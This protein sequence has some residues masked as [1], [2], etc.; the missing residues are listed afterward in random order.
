MLFS[1]IHGTRRV[2]KRQNLELVE[3]VCTSSD[4]FIVK[5]SPLHRIVQRVDAKRSMLI[6]RPSDSLL[7]HGHCGTSSFFHNK[8]R[9]FIPDL[10][11]THSAMQT[12]KPEN[13]IPVSIAQWIDHTK[14]TFTPG[15][16]EAECIKTLCAEARQAGFYAVCVQPR[17]VA[18]AK[19][20]LSG[21]TVK[22]A[23]V[24][25]FPA[26]KVQLAQERLNATVG[27]PSTAIKVAQASQAVLDGAD[28]LDIVLAVGEFKASLKVT[29]ENRNAPDSFHSEESR[30]VQAELSSI[31]QAAPNLYLKVIL[32]TDLLDEDEI[33]AAVVLCVE[34]GMDMVKT[35]TGMVEGG[36]GATEAVI[37]TL[38]NA[39]AELQSS[40]GIKASGGVKT[41]QQA[42]TLI[43]AGATRIGSSSGLALLGT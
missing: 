21:S 19:A 13:S 9:V 17:H 16:T 24:I 23:T 12:N 31:R 37:R 35:S 43:R 27:N 3:A 5:D 36:H 42:R 25:G 41:T 6:A 26:A 39:L 7:W 2:R 28:E 15:E 29:N 33:K 30:D 1:Q 40:V 22:V 11:R 8:N 38:A 20:E 18:L 14:L 34:T 4:F 32:E 10:E